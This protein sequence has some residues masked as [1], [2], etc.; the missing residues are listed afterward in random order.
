MG[1]PG[2]PAK[3]IN[4]PVELTVTVEPLLGVC[5]PV[6]PYDRETLYRDTTNGDL[7]LVTENQGKR[8]VQTLTKAL[9]Y[10]F[11]RNIRTG[12]QRLE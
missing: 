10:E 1:K 6:V 4:R 8:Y 3:K 12:I 2:R 7:Y 5:R 9:V 11:V